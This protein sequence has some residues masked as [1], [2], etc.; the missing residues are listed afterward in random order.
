M[1]K[2]KGQELEDYSPA[3]CSKSVSLESF[4]RLSKAQLTTVVLKT[5]NPSSFIVNIYYGNF[6]ICV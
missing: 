1:S 5:M 3:I 2:G 6:L 4:L